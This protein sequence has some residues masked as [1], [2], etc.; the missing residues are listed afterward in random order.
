FNFHELMYIVPIYNQRYLNFIYLE[1][2][3]LVHK[4][5]IRKEL[6]EAEIEEEKSVNYFFQLLN[7]FFYYFQVIFML[8][9]RHNPELKRLK[10][11]N[12]RGKIEFFPI[13]FKFERIGEYSKK[14]PEIEKF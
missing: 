14:F 10:E 2:K 1:N 13:D 9:S 8:V 11:N 6:L 12:K 7:F 5:N 3:W 4:Y